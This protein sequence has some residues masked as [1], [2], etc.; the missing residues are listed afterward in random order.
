MSLCNRFEKKLHDLELTRIISLQMG[1]VGLHLGVSGFHSGELVLFLAEEPGEAF[2]LFAGG[3]ALQFSYQTGQGAEDVAALRDKA[4]AS[5]SQEDAQAYNDLV[6]LCNR[7]EK[8]RRIR[9]S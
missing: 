9:L 8:K 5:G 2:F 7:F 4:A 3:E 6:S 1:H